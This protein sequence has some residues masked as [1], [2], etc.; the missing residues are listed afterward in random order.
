MV[1]L[2]GEGKDLPSFLP[3]PLVDRV[4][5]VLGGVAVR[6]CQNMAWSL[7]SGGRAC[8]K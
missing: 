7:G 2:V 3:L 1:F 4:W 6:A 8:P 5:L